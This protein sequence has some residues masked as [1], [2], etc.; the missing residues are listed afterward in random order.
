MACAWMILKLTAESSLLQVVTSNL[1]CSALDV[2]I[3]SEFNKI[4]EI[5]AISGF[6]IKSD[7]QHFFKAFIA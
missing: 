1:S 5:F 6:S 4:F 3:K 7:S 2:D